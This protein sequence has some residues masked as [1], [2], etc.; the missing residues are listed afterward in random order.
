MESNS[1]VSTLTVSG[2]SGLPEILPYEA[3]SAIPAETAPEPAIALAEAQRKSAESGGDS[4][5][6][7][8]GFH[9]CSEHFAVEVDGACKEA[10]ER[11]EDDC[12]PGRIFW[13]AVYDTDRAFG[14]REEGGWWFDYGTLV[15]D[16]KLYAEIG[17][18]PSVHTHLSDARKAQ[19]AM[20]LA[21]APLN[22]GNPE[23][24]SVLCR[25]VY[26]AEI[27]ENELPPFYPAERPQYE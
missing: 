22:E 25:G 24:G 15:S 13:V 14:G 8:K 4:E 23:I 5:S 19:T 26:A 1:A 6:L 3:K 17:L 12:I 20:R 10:T 21:L 2:F 18:L 16:G 9:F 11:N 7:P 27:H